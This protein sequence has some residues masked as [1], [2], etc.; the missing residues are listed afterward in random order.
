MCQINRSS[1][2]YELT[3]NFSPA[4][5]LDR[6][7][8]F[9]T[10]AEFVVSLARDMNPPRGYFDA[11]LCA[12]ERAGEDRQDEGPEKTGTQCAALCVYTYRAIRLRGENASHDSG[13]RAHSLSGGPMSKL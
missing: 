6:R 13:F 3:C 2:S 8:L 5:Y 9:L 11:F 1:A 4:S 7:S 12:K 10:L